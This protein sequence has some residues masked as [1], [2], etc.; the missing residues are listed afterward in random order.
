MKFGFIGVGNMG[1]PMALNLVKAGHSLLV[2]DIRREAAANLEEAG[3]TWVN[4]PR[5][6]ATGVEATFLSLPMPADV[7]RVVLAANGVLAGMRSG[8]TI[9]DMSTNS[10]AVVR[11]LAEKTK[12]KGVVFLDA[13]VSGGVRGA[14]NAT[15]AIMVGGDKAVYDK[16]EPA[17]K[18]IGANVFHC[19]DVGNGNVVKLVNNMLAFIHMMGA[20]EAIV[21]GTKA[22]VDP[23]ILWQAV[24][25]SSGGSFVWESGTRAIL[26]DRLA[27]TFTIDLASKDI[28]LAAALA[29]EIGVPL[30]MGT[31]AKELIQHYQASGY[32]KEDVLATVKELEKQTGTVVRGTWK[33][34]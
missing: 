15:L 18:A 26:R 13:P 31:A 24:K 29:N 19:G 16:Y 11:S 7:E 33:E 1:N 30:T 2:H 6:A 14:R 3:A 21:L 4:S 12:A 5:E 27:P 22:G 25:A 34:S 20:A 8:G 10:P 28:S 23:N 32:A 17:L 9:I